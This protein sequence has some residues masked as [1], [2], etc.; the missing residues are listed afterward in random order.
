M[1]TNRMYTLTSEDQVDEKKDEHG[2]KRQLTTVYTLQ[3]NGVAER[4]NRTVMNMV[5]ALLSAKSIPKTLW[6]EDVNWTCDILNRCPTLAVKDITPYEA[7][8]GAKPSVEHLKA[9]GCLAH[10]HVPKVNRNK[11]DN[12]SNVCVFFGVNEGTKGYR[13][14]DV[15]A[16][17]IVISRDVVF[18]EDKD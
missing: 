2:I 14:F 4:K 13:L 11:L 7:W 9:W 3:Q 5:R 15:E 6:P 8:S 16:K 10:V 12:R 18:E 1:S 17:K